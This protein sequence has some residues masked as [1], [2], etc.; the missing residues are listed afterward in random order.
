MAGKDRTRHNAS[1]SVDEARRMDAPA[2]PPPGPLSALRANHPIEVTPTDPRAQRD[3]IYV[4]GGL[5]ALGMIGVVILA[6]EGATEVALALLGV[7][8]TAIGAVGVRRGQ[9]Q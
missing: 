2:D 4:L 1:P 3:S 9:S 5:A 8:T 7:S 6:M